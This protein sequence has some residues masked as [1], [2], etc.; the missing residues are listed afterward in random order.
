MSWCADRGSERYRRC[1]ERR[2]NEIRQEPAPDSLE[3]EGVLPAET[4]YYDY[5]TNTWTEVEVDTS[6]PGMAM[7]AMAY[8]PATTTVVVFGGEMT[9]KYAG[10]LS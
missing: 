3:D 2:R 7:Y 8:D 9:S 1:E 10:N 4:W 5:N 6:P